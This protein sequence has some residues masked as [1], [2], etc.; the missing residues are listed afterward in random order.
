MI[1]DPG[2]LLLRV[3]EVDRRGE[4]AALKQ[5]HGHT[6][7]QIVFQRRAFPEL[8]QIERL[9]SNGAVESNSRIKFGNRDA[10]ISGRF[11]QLRFRSANVGAPA[12]EIRRNAQRACAAGGGGMALG[13]VSSAAR[14]PGGA[15]SNRLRALTA[16]DSWRSRSGIVARTESTCAAAFSTSRPVTTPVLLPILGNVENIG[17][18]LDVV[19]GD[20]DLPM[21]AAQLHIVARHFRRAPKRGCHAAGPPRHQCRHRRLRPGAVH[22]PRYR[23]PT[24]RRNPVAIDRR[25]GAH[26][27]VADYPR[28]P[29][30][31][32][33]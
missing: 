31:R 3:A 18:G 29:Q 11:V 24:R 5:R 33:Y 13:A 9:E 15:S 26:S 12:R 16:S 2:F 21:D 25:A 1:I 4:L 7:P 20:P 28:R 32:C 22:A 6:W 17:L 10:D 19:T 23:A 30:G 27:A 14:P 8:L